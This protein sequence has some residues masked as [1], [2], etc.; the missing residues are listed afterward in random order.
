MPT[1]IQQL[2]NALERFAPTAYQESYDNAGL[3]VGNPQTVIT[4]VLVTLD[5][6]EEVLEEAL[7]KGCNVIVAHHPIVF[8]GLK[9]LTGKNYVERVILKAIKND[10]AIYAIHTNLDNVAGGVN[11]KIAETLGLQNVRILAPKPQT[12]MKLTTFAP[13]EATESILEKLGQAGA[14][15]IGAYKNC[16]FTTEGQG[17]FLPTQHAQPHI[18]LVGKLET[19]AEN[20]IE[21]ILPAHAQ[22]A[23]IR[24]L[25]EAHPYEEIAYYLQ[26]VENQNQEV[27]S[28]AIGNLPAPIAENDFLTYL[29]TQM[30]LACI[31]HT[32][33]RGRQV[34]SVAVCGGTGS[35][36]LNNAIRQGADVFISADFKYHEFFDADSRIVIADIGHYE[37]EV[38]T[39]HLLKDYLQTF[40]MDLSIQTTAVNT[41]PISY[42]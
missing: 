16:S 17:R 15:Q 25:R 41:N 39:S 19:V 14:G 4:G 27:G 34:Q 21:V 31:R 26:N 32:P 20:R 35:F 37:S 1:T 24:A 6:T 42:F 33:L 30:H 38:N 18:G 5:S 3:I 12:L 23:V 40:F 11:F 22:S 9:Q 28:G 10:L 8:K 2:T 29:K 7:Q 36:L 13:L